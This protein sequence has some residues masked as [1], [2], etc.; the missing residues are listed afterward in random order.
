MNKRFLF[1]VSLLMLVSIVLF[2]QLSVSAQ[3]GETPTPSVRE[4]GPA[5]LG[6]RYGEPLSLPSIS[7]AKAIGIAK[8]WAGTKAERAVEIDAKYVLFSDDQYYTVDIRG[9]INNK[10]QDVP[11]WVITFKGVDTLTRRGLLKM[12]L[13]VVV[14]ALTGEYME[15]FDYG[16]D[17]Q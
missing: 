8:F 7:Q 4:V 11:A 10:F 12:D 5:A 1:G 3:K 16:S 6:I 17:Q 14:N 2:S 13:N 9:Q 15:E